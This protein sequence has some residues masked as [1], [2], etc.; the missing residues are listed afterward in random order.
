VNVL[1]LLELGRRAHQSGQ[2]HEAEVIYRQILA[3]DPQQPDAWHLLGLI[4][5]EAGQLAAALEYIDRALT[6]DARMAPFWNSRGIVCEASGQHEKAAECFRRALGLTP[7]YAEAHSNL[8]SCL[9][10]LGRSEEALEHFR[11][12]ARL[13]PVVLPLQ[14]NLARVLYRLRHLDEAAAV[15]REAMAR[16][17][18]EAEPPFLLSKVL[19]DQGQTAEEIAALRESLRCRPA[20]PEALNHLGIALARSGDLAEARRVLDEAIRLQ[21]GYADAYNNLGNVYKRLGQFAEAEHAYLHAVRSEPTSADLH[22]NLARLWLDHNRPADAL[23][24]LRQ[25]QR[26]DP[27]RIDV[28][29]AQAAGLAQMGRLRE[30]VQARRKVLEL[31]PRDHESFNELGNL[32]QETEQFEAA[33]SAYRKAIELQ[34]DFV[35]ARANLACMLADQGLSEEARDQYREAVRRQPTPILRL[36]AETV[37]PVIYSSVEEIR[38]TRAAFEDSLRRMNAEGLRIDPTRETMPTLFYLAYQ[39]LNDR[40][41]HRELARLCDGPRAVQPQLA[42]PT[43][44]KIRVGFLSRYLRDHT[45]G[46]LNAGTIRELSRDKFDV[47][48]LNVGHSDD[49]LARRI[50]ESADHAVQVPHDLRAAMET[51]AGQGLDVLIYTDLGMA[52]FTY[53]LAFSRLAPVQCVSWGHPMTTGISTIDYFLSSEDLETAASDAHYSE[54][55]V[56]MKRLGVCYERPQLPATPK[57]RAFYGL[58][59]D[60]HLYGCPQTLFKFHPEFDALLAEILRRD[61][62]GM[63][64]LVEGRYPA[65]QRLLAAR[66]RRTLPGGDT[67]VR[68]LPRLTHTDFLSLMAACDVLLDPIHF[69]GGNSSYEGLALGVPIVTLPS[70][71]LRGRITYAQYRQ[72]NLMDCVAQN[73]DDYVRLAVE[74]GTNRRRRTALSERILAQCAVLFNDRAAV[75]ELEQFL[76]TVA[77]KGKQ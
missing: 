10:E 35:P 20:Y 31:A 58:P 56:R 61:P 69:G 49:E 12:A 33:E 2:F 47:T 30:A 16:H 51:V 66:L 4:A 21:P 59:D 53:T 40:D 67:W 11:Q 65:W 19:R 75:E 73:T 1:Q 37:T 38:S 77:A 76:T 54:Q 74:L 70:E 17:P 36:L 26:L 7:E 72:M 15:L 32:L 8:G 18:Q 25:A 22:L 46:R 27:Q 60:A 71:F 50:R 43:G 34:A 64:V 62:Q 9:N 23:V 3:A 13:R 5:Q 39:G 41:I 44:E 45:I 28:V 48:V 63:L 52:P 42:R 14:L 55:L 68:F 57:P 29:R 6:I 24:S